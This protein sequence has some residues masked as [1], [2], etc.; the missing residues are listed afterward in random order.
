M[1]ATSW[2]VLEKEVRVKGC[3]SAPEGV[4]LH[5]IAGSSHTPQVL[6]VCWRMIGV[7]AKRPDMGKP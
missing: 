3:R 6:Q 5:L 1:F 2:I 4:M 7:L